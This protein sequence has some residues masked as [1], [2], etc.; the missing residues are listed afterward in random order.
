MAVKYPDYHN[1]PVGA[2][3]TSRP[4]ILI[5]GLA[6]GLHGAHRTGRAFVG[7]DSG[8]FLFQGLAA[9]DLA[10][11]ADPA[12]AKLQQVRITNIVKCLP[13]ANAPESSEVNNCASFLSAEL[14][15]F[16]ATASRLHRVIVALGGSAYRQLTRHY[17]PHAKT[18]A[19]PFA[20]GAEWQC[21]P[22]LHLLASFHPSRL[23]VNTGRM[24]APMLKEILLRAQRLTGT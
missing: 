12:K 6:P 15:S 11:D 18:K 3:G 5:V 7:D 23:N 24:T 8:R 1:A 22:R 13:P 4:K 9:T 2:W 14:Q 16:H 20:H 10:S 21:G 17:R 19:P